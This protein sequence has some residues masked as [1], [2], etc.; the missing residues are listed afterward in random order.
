MRFDAI[1]YAFVVSICA[2]QRLLPR[3]PASRQNVVS[4][5]ASIHTCTALFA[6]LQEQTMAKLNYVMIVLVLAGCL[7]AG[8]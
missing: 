1:L 6:C 8:R 3:M 4:Q 5:A 2:A 7:L